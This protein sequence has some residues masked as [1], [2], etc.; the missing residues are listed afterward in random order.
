MLPQIQFSYE[1]TLELISEGVRM[2]YQKCELDRAEKPKYISQNKAYKKF[3]RTRVE[4]WVERGLINYKTKSERGDTTAKWYEY[5]RLEELD[6]ANQITI[7]KAQ[8]HEK[9]S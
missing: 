3:E 7:Y 9:T 2:G 8:N 4:D 6:I 5:A 1:D